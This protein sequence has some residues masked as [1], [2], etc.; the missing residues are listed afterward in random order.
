VACRGSANELQTAT[1]TAFA[2]QPD[3]EIIISFPGLGALTGARVLAE[4]GDDRSRFADAR[5]I[6]AYAGAAPIARA[7][8]RRQ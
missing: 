8:E 5:A 4:L 1:V 6:K 2:T 7:S 3:A